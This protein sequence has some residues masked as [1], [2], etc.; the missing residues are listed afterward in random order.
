M[1]LGEEA[2][3]QAG[4]G[5]NFCVIKV[6]NRKIK[7]TCKSGRQRMMCDI[8]L[9]QRRGTYSSRPNNEQGSKVWARDEACQVLR[10]ERQACRTR[11]DHVLWEAD[12]VERYRV[13]C[14]QLVVR[15][16][17]GACAW[18]PDERGG[19][20]RGTFSTHG[21]KPATVRK[22][23]QGRKHEQSGAFPQ[24]H[25]CR[26]LDPCTVDDSLGKLQVRALAGRSKCI[27]DLSPALK[28]GRGV[29][30]LHHQ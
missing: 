26:Q 5:R 22:D 12:A 29:P 21:N 3:D 2:V 15:E 18:R 13:L 4:R 24:P 23:A 10:R 1:T 9:R 27:P 14:A 8:R 6:E 7:A 19:E 11:M 16:R 30:K 20:V 25:T 17:E 28:G